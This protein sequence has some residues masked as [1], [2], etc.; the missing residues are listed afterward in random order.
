MANCGSTRILTCEKTRN[1]YG[2]NYI[3]FL[4]NTI[5]S[6]FRLKNAQCY[7]KDKK[8]QRHSD[9]EKKFKSK[10]VCPDLELQRTK[11]KSYFIKK[12]S[13]SNDIQCTIV[14]ISIL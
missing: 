10:V 14:F 9:N 1:L 2:T 5:I 4:K 8:R 7:L 11:C 3:I 6:D 13:F 12:L